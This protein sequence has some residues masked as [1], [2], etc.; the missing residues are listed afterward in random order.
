MRSRFL[1]IGTGGTINWDPARGSVTTAEVVNRVARGVPAG[2][3][4]ETVDLDDRPGPSLRF[5]DFVRIAEYV[6]SIGAEFDGVAVLCG[7]EVAVW[8]VWALQL[9]GLERV[10]RVVV[11]V[12]MNPWSD[13]DWDGGRNLLDAL[14]FL[15]A[16]CLPETTPLLCSEGAL[17][18]PA[19][20][21]KQSQAGLGS[22]ASPRVGPVATVEPEVRLRWASRQ[23]P[24]HTSTLDASVN[25]ITCWPNLDARAFL[26]ASRRSRAVVVRGLGAGVLPSAV[27]EAL[28]TLIERGVMAVVLP[29]TDAPFGYS[30]EQESAAL[31]H[32]R[33]FDLPR[34]HLLVAAAL[35][36]RSKIDDLLPWLSAFVNWAIANERQAH[37]DCVVLR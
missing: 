12:S 33:G 6:L 1:V 29:E 2:S 37:N 5:D 32:V 35:G 13:D 21:R 34:A 24:E 19:W 31:I 8:L 30:V 18:A 3:T 4:V 15:A 16:D 36:Y 23:S 14:H 22:F 17:H 11:V 20:V 7:S 26:A 10:V 27:M 25:A 28:P 9:L